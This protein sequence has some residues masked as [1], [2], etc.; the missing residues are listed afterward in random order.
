MNIQASLNPTEPPTCAL[1]DEP[2]ASFVVEVREQGDGMWLC[3]RHLARLQGQVESVPEMGAL[4]EGAL[5]VTEI[6]PDTLGASG[7]A[8]GQGGEA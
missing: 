5:V 7:G 2:G 4:F 1:C 8:D 6:T 3:Q